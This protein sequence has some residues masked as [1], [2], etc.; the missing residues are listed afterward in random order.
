MVSTTP[1]PA[2]M[3]ATFFAC[4]RCDPHLNDLG[5][6][7]TLKPGCTHAECSGGDSSS[8]SAPTNSTHTT[9]RRGARP[10][11]QTQ[12][13]QSHDALV[14]ALGTWIHDISTQVH[15]HLHTY[16]GSR[17]EAATSA[18]ASAVQSRMLSRPAKKKKNVCVI[19]PQNLTI[20]MH[21]DTPSR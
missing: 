6:R 15:I 17:A 12:I 3:P 4:I 21:C 9:R 20:I 13:V 5:L 14:Q 8:T 18:S 10:L 19:H 1:I 2:G 16:Q 11:T 7:K